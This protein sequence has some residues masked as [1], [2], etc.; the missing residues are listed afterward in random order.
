VERKKWEIEWAVDREINGIIAIT[1][2]LSRFLQEEG[3]WETPEDLLEILDILKKDLWKLARKTARLED[4]YEE[5]L[6]S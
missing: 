4:L 6:V 2:D 5:I 1:A 3:A